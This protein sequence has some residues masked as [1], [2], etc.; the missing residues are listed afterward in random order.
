MKIEFASI[1][2]RIEI[3]VFFTTHSQYGIAVGLDDCY[4]GDTEKPDV[5]P[6]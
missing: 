2:C 1:A 3:P 6:Q 4:A 5:K